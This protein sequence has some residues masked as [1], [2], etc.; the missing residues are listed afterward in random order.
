MDRGMECQPWQRCSP[1]LA[2]AILHHVTA[3]TV[4][5][6]VSLQC[7]P[8]QASRGLPMAPELLRSARELPLPPIPLMRAVGHRQAS[9]DAI[10]EQFIAVGKHFVHHFKTLIGLEPE[11]RVLEVGC[12]CGRIARQLTDALDSTG[13]YDGIDVAQHHVQWCTDNITTHYPNFHFWHGDIH[14][15]LYNPSG[16]LRAADYSFP[17]DTASFDFVFLTSVFT[18]MFPRDIDRYM[19]EITRVL[20]PG[21]RTFITY[22][23]LNRE[24][25]AANATGNTAVHFAPRRWRP[26]WLSDPS[27]PEA[28]VALEER[29]VTK[30]HEREGMLIE[31]VYYGSW[32]SRRTAPSF[33]DIMVATRMDPAR[34]A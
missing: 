9:D 23:L 32:V 24:S 4:M 28:V 14:N 31:R 2:D 15:T 25:R 17:F 19:A 1:R 10:P 3:W 8:S 33:Q 27:I 13:S 7:E 30:Q 34:P 29:L 26:Y 11:W 12:G 16:R 5:I 18:H 6:G 20:R 22:Y 21:G